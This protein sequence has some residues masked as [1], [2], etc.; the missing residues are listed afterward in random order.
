MATIRHNRARG[1]HYVMSMADIVTELIDELNI[2]PAELIKRLGMEK[3]EVSR[4]LDRGQ[5]I[6]RAGNDDYKPAWVAE[7]R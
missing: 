1:E 5:M 4:L 3:E 7:K 6:K 2:E